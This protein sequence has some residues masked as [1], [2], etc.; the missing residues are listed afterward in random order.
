MN[1]KSLVVC[2][3]LGLGDIVSVSA[4][5]KYLATQYVKVYLFTKVHYYKNTTD[6]YCDIAN[7][8]VIPIAGQSEQMEIQEVNFWIQMLQPDVDIKTCGLY[9][10]YRNS[11]VNP[12]KNFYKD[13]ELEFE[14]CENHFS[15][16]EYFWTLHKS[17]LPSRYVFIC[18]KSSQK[19]FLDQ[20]LPFVD[21]ENDLIIDPNI[22]VY[23][24]NHAY[25]KIAAKYVGRP[26]FEYCNIIKNANKV[27]V[28][29][30][31]FSILARFICNTNTTQCILLNCSHLQY[32][33]DF[34]HNWTIYKQ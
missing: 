18:S 7:V 1:K 27:V 28:I 12:P 22:N 3:H 29:D 14:Q 11:L 33:V 8:F 20:V 31:A 24:E 32:T 19:S 30:S 34:F 15:I 5:V 9:S 16:P 2:N 25:H 21:W 13:W 17:D 10:N 6:L 26:F 4:G 23:P